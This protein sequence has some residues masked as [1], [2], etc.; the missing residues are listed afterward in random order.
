MLADEKLWNAKEKKSSCSR[1]AREK[2]DFICIQKWYFAEAANVCFPT[3]T[4]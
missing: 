4:D 3:C 1:R 2:K